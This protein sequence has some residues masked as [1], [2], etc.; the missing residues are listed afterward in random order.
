MQQI[1]SSQTNQFKM[2]DVGQLH[3]CLGV[4]INICGDQLQL[5]QKHY[6]QKLLEKYGLTEAKPVSTPSD[7]KVKL[8]KDDSYSK[9]VE[10]VRYQ[11]MVGSLL[12]VSK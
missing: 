4:T 9:S 5:S 10:P 3:Y 7:R 6:I 2:K 11:S 8:V 1:K 12:Y